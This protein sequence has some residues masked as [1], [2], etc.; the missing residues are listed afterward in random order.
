MRLSTTNLRTTG[1]ILLLGVFG[2]VYAAQ[3]QTPASQ[4]QEASPGQSEPQ[5]AA[6]SPSPSQTAIQQPQASV[7]ARGGGN[8][9]G[10]SFWD[11]TLT[12]WIQVGINVVLLLVVFWQARINRSQ[13]QTMQR[14]SEIMQGELDITRESIKQ[15]ERA[16]AANEAMA[17]AAEESAKIAREAFYIGERPYFGVTGMGIHWGGQHNNDPSLSLTLLNGGQTPAWQLRVKAFL[18]LG[19]APDTGHTYPLIEFKTHISK[20]FVPADQQVNLVFLSTHKLSPSEINQ[21]RKQRTMRLF[22]SVFATY[23][24]MRSQIHEDDFTAAF[25]PDDNSLEDWSN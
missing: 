18:I 16:L 13:R 8:Q 7:E 20:R 4:Q 9:A 3:G 21:I 12:D 2:V 11:A 17:K 22:V 19:D 5:P 6:V 24:D 23:T 25:R 14:Q 1:F 10:N 15:S